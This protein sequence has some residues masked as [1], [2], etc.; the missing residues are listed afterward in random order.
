MCA[1]RL[2]RVAVQPHD[3]RVRDRSADVLLDALGPDPEM[4]DARR[5]AAG[6]GR[7]GPR[8]LAAAAVTHEPA[9]GVERERDLARRAQNDVA[10]VAAE[11]DG[12]EAPPVQI[13]DRLLALGHRA[14]Q[15]GTQRAR[16]GGAIVRLELEAKVDDPGLR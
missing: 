2:H 9:I 12:R 13:E 15:R 16:E 5:A 6:T 11:H 4:A 7:R 3:P 14:L 8:L 1:L 10:A